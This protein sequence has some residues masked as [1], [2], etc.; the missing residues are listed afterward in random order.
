MCDI[1][2]CTSITPLP[3][4][5][6]GYSSPNAGAARWI[7][8]SSSFEAHGRCCEV[9]ILAPWSGWRAE[10]PF[11]GG[12]VVTSGESRGGKAERY[13]PPRPTRSV[14]IY[15]GSLRPLRGSAGRLGPTRSHWRSSEGVMRGGGVSDEW[16]AEGR[17]GGPLPPST[18]HAPDY[19][20]P[21]KPPAARWVRWSPWADVGAASGGRQKG[22]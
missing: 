3:P 18:A 20:L 5:R 21:Q 16:S 1:L 17:Q 2:P 10:A 6:I 9:Q 4:S 22:C 15:L 13:H 12:M 19:Y 14:T 8:L 7:H 11:I